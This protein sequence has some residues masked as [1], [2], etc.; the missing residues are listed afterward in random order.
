MKRFQNSLENARQRSTWPINTAQVIAVEAAVGVR[1]T[2]ADK[3]T[4]PLQ[5]PKPPVSAWVDSGS[6][7][8]GPNHSNFSHQS[9][10]KTLGI[11]RKPRKATFIEVAFDPKYKTGPQENREKG[12]KLLGQNSVEIQYMLLARKNF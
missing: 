6:I 1:E 3:P 8:E 9:L 11:Q 4:P 7:G 5:P 12:N 10:V 2:I